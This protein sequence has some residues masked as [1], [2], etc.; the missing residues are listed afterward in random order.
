MK[1][2]FVSLIGLPNA[3]KS[4]LV[5]AL[6]GEKVGIVSNKP[7]TT[8]RR[9]VGI[10]ND[11]SMQV[12]FIDSPGRIRAAEG[13]NQFLEEECDSVMKDG[14]VLAAILNVDSTKLEDL[15]DIARAVAAQNKP[16][17]AIITKTDLDDGHREGRLREELRALRSNAPTVAVA[18]NKNPAGVRNRV[19]PFL[20]ELL[21]EAPPLFSNDIYTTQ[22]TRELVA[23]I[24]REKCFECVHEEVPYGLA[25]QILK[26][27]ETSSMPRIH[28]EI[29]VAKPNFVPIVL[30]EKGR[31]IRHIGVESRREI[32]R[33][34]GKRVFLETHVK[35]KR[36]WSRQPSIMRELGYVSQ[37]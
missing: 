6:V 35:L 32:E 9:V 31:R 26:F 37:K 15:L 1:S 33:L 10:Y 27:D 11:D 30:G 16:W 4:T 14:D 22:S 12:C 34:M 21:P 5:N 7:Q 23:E 2:G 28:A 20:L 13:L 19:L 18:A 8:R 24:I 36:D 25:V 17:M 3:G 29:I